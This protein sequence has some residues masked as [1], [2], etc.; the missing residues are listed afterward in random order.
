MNAAHPIDEKQTDYNKVAE[1]KY[2]TIPNL[3]KRLTEIEQQL[4][5]VKQQGKSGINDMVQPEDIATIIS[6]R[7]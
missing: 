3:Q 2:S 7:T 4:E 6:K 5:D 1:I